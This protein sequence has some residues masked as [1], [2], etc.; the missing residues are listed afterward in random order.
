MRLLTDLAAVAAG[1]AALVAACGAVASAHGGPF[2]F[3]MP[4]VR[5]AEAI[6]LSNW[7]APGYAWMLEEPQLLIPLFVSIVA[8]ALLA[9]TRF[10]NWR[11]DAQLRYSAATTVFSVYMLI[12]LTVWEFFGGADFFEVS[13]YFSIFLVPISLVIPSILYLI[14]RNNRGHLDRVST[15]LGLGIVALPVAV[16]FVVRVG[17]IERHGFYLVAVLMLIAVL[18][19]FAAAGPSA[20]PSRALALLGISL[21]LASTSYASASGAFTVG[22]FGAP[23]PFGER[24]AALSMSVQLMNFVRA[25]GVQ[26]SALPPGFWYDVTTTTTPLNGIQSTYLWGITAIGWHMPHLGTSERQLLDARRPPYLVLLCTSPTC[27]GA[28]ATLRRAG[29]VNRLRAE[30]VIA[31]GGWRYWVEALRLPEYPLAT[32]WTVWSPQTAR[33]RRLLRRLVSPTVELTSALPKRTTAAR[34]GAA[35]KPTPL[36][37]G[38]GA[39]ART[40][41]RRCEP[42]FTRLGRPRTHASELGLALSRAARARNPSSRGVGVK[43]SASGAS[44]VPPGFAARSRASW[45]G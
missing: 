32:A 23:S 15:L 43:P 35:V 6:D 29:Y 11:R 41:S 18:V 39:A 36:C 1:T 26:R 45:S 4:S 30:T 31:S 44:L 22:Q 37:W 27:A 3:F 7:K 34:C 2:F 19:T 33:P 25:S 13:Y 28:R 9:R 42:S 38:T 40:R 24:R 5:E 17:P 16:L 8:V 12:I 14:V 21:V 20:K 10:R